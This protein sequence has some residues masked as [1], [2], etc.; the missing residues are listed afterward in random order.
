MKIAKL[1]VALLV[2]AGILA[3]CGGGGGAPFQTPPPTTS[4]GVATTTVSASSSTIASDG[5]TTS[6]ITGILRDKNQNFVSGAAVT[7]TASAGGLASPSVKSD[8][9]GTVTATLSASGAAAGTAIKVTVTSGTVSGSATVTVSATTRTLTVTTSAP[10]IP[11][12]GSKSATITALVRDGNNNIVGGVPVSFATD[13]GSL[14]IS[15]TVTDA[16]G[17]AAATLTTAGDQT[18][19]IIHVTA[20]LAGDP[21]V[22]I[23]VSVTGTTLNVT[24]TPAIVTGNAATYTIQLSNSAGTGIPNQPVAV[25]SAL[26]NTLSAASVSTNATG[27]ATVT[28]TAKTSGTDTLSATALGLTAT[29]TISISG[30]SFSF[31]SPAPAPAA[32]P[33]VNLGA[34]YTAVVQWSSNGTPVVG[35]PV[36]FSTTRGTLSAT[37]VNTDATGKAS[38]T[39]TAANAGPGILTASGNGVSAQATIDFVATT[40]ATV[41]LQPSATAVPTQGTSTILAVVRDP[42]GNLVQGQQVQFVLT[43][44]TNGT[45]STGLSVTDVQGVAQ[46]VYTASSTASSK[47]GVIIT[48]TVL[49]FPAVTAQTTLT[50]GGQAVFLSLGTG[51]IINEYSQAEYSQDWSVRAID[52]Q[53]ATVPNVPVTIGVTSVAY[54]KGYYC[55]PGSGLN[56][57]GQTCPTTGTGWQQILTV[58]PVISLCA[59]EDLNGNGILDPGEDFNGNGKLDPG[60]VASVSPGALKTDATGL[61]PFTLYYPKDHAT[62]VV[63]TITA[64]AVVTGT[65]STTSA[66]ITLQGASVDYQTLTVSPPG[67]FSPYGYASSCANPN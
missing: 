58:T 65:Q 38:V 17:L 21:P 32:V 16:N 46:T 27:Q 34:T 49:G 53:G 31:T 8:S 4:S 1:L 2:S 37:V 60:S 48:A 44:V 24:G 7:F 63:V 41:T 13:S 57:S 20:S 55:A 62:W 33:T 5:S 23:P 43:D 47:N 26:G 29:Q 25:T 50:V 39:V 56:L 6:V 11:S 66:T 40:P 52:A 15:N 14:A 36:T 22:T 9:T 19:R 35:S 10:Q 30:Q 59:N 12:D 28:L 54:L 67:P 61:L 45:L 64:S 3:G 18:N 51:N 42:T